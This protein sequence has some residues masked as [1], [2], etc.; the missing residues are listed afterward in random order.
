MGLRWPPLPTARLRRKWHEGGTTL[1]PRSA[2]GQVDLASSRAEA[3]SSASRRRPV[4]CARPTRTGRSRRPGRLRTTAAGSAASLRKLHQRPSSSSELRSARRSIV[5]IAQLRSRSAGC[6]RPGVRYPTLTGR[7]CDEGIRHGGGRA[8]AAAD[9]GRSMEARCATSAVDGTVMN[10]RC[11]RSRSKMTS[12][13]TATMS[14][15][16]SAGRTARPSMAR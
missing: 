5:G 13:I 11:G 9:G 2:P 14:A 4:Q 7:C 12:S 16:T 6:A 15:P 10:P 1:P 3:G 8:G